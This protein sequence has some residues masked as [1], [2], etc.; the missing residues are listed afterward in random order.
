VAKSENEDVDHRSASV[1]QSAFYRRSSSIAAL[2]LAAASPQITTQ[3]SREGCRKETI[4]DKDSRLESSSSSELSGI[5][6]SKGAV[7]RPLSLP[8]VSHELSRRPSMKKY[9]ILEDLTAG[10]DLPCVMDIKMGVRQ[11]SVRHYNRPEKLAVT[12]KKSINT[13]SSLL[14]FR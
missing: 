14:G 11:R 5:N 10:L 13:T 8:S 9:L 12:L 1:L 4:Y 6:S 2:S 3:S 7:T